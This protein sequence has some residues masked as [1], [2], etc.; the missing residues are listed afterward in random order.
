MRLVDDQQPD[1]SSEE[2]QH[3]LAEARVIQPLRADQQQVD[4]PV[5]QTIA[6][7]VPFLPVGRVDRV[8]PQPEAL[9][10]HQLVAHQRQ[11]RAH[12]QRRTRPGLPQKRRGDEVDSG[13]PPS[14]PLDAEHPRSVHHHVADRR[15]LAVAELGGRVAGQRPQP[16]QSGRR[17]DLRGCRDHLFIVA[18]GRPNDTEL[19][20]VANVDSD[21]RVRRICSDAVRLRKFGSRAS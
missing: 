3:V 14:G 18:R 2:R 8:R 15:Q 1:R 9:R 11:Q 10:S 13:F 4:R 17:K 20:H 7:T 5:R 16:L 6:H 19:I 12:D 21:S